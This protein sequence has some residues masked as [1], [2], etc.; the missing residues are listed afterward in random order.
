MNRLSFVFAIGILA[1]ATS[2]GAECVW[3]WDCTSGQCERV[4]LCQNA[5]DVVMPAMPEVPPIPMP[6]VRPIPQPMVPPIGAT[7]CAPTY[8]CEQSG[9]AWMT[10]CR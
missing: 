4:P 6:S 10:T 1:W 8:I 3:T 7:S 9:C 5:T 2:A